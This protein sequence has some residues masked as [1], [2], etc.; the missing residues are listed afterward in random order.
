MSS[1]DFSLPTKELAGISL[2]R[3]SPHDAA[4]ELCRMAKSAGASRG[5]G[6]HLVNA[7]TVAL[8]HQ[9]SHYAKLLN[10]SSANFP[11]GKPL[12]WWRHSDGLRLRQ[13]R[14]PQLFEDVMDLGRSKNVRHYLLGSSPETLKLLKDGLRRRYPGVSIVGMFS[15]PF[16]KMS[17]D[18]IQRQ[19]EEIIRTGAEIVWVGLGT[20]KQDWE[21]GRIAAHLPVLAIA[22]GAAFDFSAGTKKKS[23]EWISSLGM[24]WLFRLVTEPRRLWKRYLI[25]N[26]VFLWSV[27]SRRARK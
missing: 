14:G 22:V 17:K 5:H 19:D 13:I 24:E 20:P 18:E 23:P 10:S 4:N 11:D 26:L 25:G 21:V 6:F 16:R 2:V 15:P 12:T 27:V 7:Y 1:K 9:D 8:A 3:A